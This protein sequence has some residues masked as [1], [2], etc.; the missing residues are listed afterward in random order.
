MQGTRRG[1]APRNQRR[2]N[3]APANA[4]QLWTKGNGKLQK[5]GQTATGVLSFITSHIKPILIVLLALVLIG[6]IDSALTSGKIYRGVHIGSVDVSGLTEQQAIEQVESAY[7]HKFNN[8][9]LTVYAGEEGK[10]KALAGEGEVDAEDQMSVE[11]V[12]QATVKWEVYPYDV[13]A[14]MQST[15]WASQAL[16]WG[17]TEGG[18]FARIGSL[19]LGKTIEPSLGFNE[20]LVENLGKKIDLTLGETRV[21]WNIAISDGVATVTEGKDGFMLDRQKLCDAMQVAF[22]ESADGKGEMIAYAEKAP[23]RINQ[24]QAQQVC[25]KVNAAIADGANISYEDATWNASAADLGELVITKIVQNGR[26]WDL[27][28]SISADKAKPTM[29]SH[30]KKEHQRPTIAVTFEKI[31]GEPYVRPSESGPIP[32]VSKG[33]DDLNA[34]LFDG[35]GKKSTG[36]PVDLTLEQTNSP[37]LMT[38]EEAN[39]FGFIEAIS[40][41][42]VAY[43]NGIGSEAK[44]NNIHLMASELN[45][46]ICKVGQ[47]W[48]FNSIVGD[49]TP[50]KGYQSAGTIIE[51]E[52]SESI[53]GGI[54]AVATT[55]FN[56]V[57]EAGLP[58]VT[59]HNH[60]LYI[61]SYPL[62][63]DAA[64][65]YPDMDLIWENDLTSDI[66]VRMSYT[67]DTV[68]CTLYGISPHLNVSTAEGEWEEGEKYKTIVKEDESLPENY[69]YTDV[70]GTD[71]ASITVTRTVTAPDGTIVRT[72]NFTSRYEPKN[73][74]IICGPNTKVEKRQDADKK[75]ESDVN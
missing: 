4:P 70:S 55:V 64:I 20:D 29:L 13:G 51:G 7:G 49:T 31:D 30:I 61:S 16:A 34:A 59:R 1:E 28:P 32:N 71:G 10:Q 15:T 27:V 47:Q 21:D 66:L 9:Q 25:D 74:V 60:S 35:N 38:F 68:T 67:D 46:T 69:K 2:G 56:T 58:V 3:H 52:Y 41:F 11:E 37:E 53:G 44:V 57:Y 6:F 33:S 42:E 22:M 43:V 73:E 45:N 5:Q 48:S 8:G 24:K 75:S 54:C 50:D 18:P 19:L 23:I 39:D 36:N 17:R 12:A 26:S 65:N 14:T 72:N 40:D 63:R 62:G